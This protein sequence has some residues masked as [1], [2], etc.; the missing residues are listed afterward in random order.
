MTV[1]TCT[2]EYAHACTYVYVQTHVYGCL[3]YMSMPDKQRSKNDVANITTS[4][5]VYTKI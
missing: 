3:M 5:A 1:H 4:S 2:M